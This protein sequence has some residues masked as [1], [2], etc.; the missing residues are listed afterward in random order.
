MAEKTR[1]KTIAALEAVYAALKD[2]E[3]EDR[4]KVLSSAFVLLG[5]ESSGFAAPSTTTQRTIASLPQTTAARP[6]SLVELVNEKKPG[7]NAQRIA[8]FA[9]YREKVEG[10][11]RFSRDDLRTYFAKARLTPAANF[12]RDFGDAVRKAW[13]H[14]DAADSYLT[15]R[16]VEAVEGGFEGERKSQKVRQAPAK[17][18][19]TSSRKS[20]R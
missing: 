3:H 6:T 11:T 20:K 13:I 2:L 12:D 4:K 5:V 17:K 19:K 9:Y 8:L 14:E 18:K 1:D 7:T 16:G 15:T 10:L